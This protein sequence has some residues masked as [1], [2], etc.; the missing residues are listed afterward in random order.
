MA[1]NAAQ[2]KQG[3]KPEAP[4]MRT[5]EAGRVKFRI[6]ERNKEVVVN[7]GFKTNVSPNEFMLMQHIHGEENVEYVGKHMRE[8]DPKKGRSGDNIERPM[9]ER[10]AEVQRGFDEKGLM[11]WEP[12]TM[13]DERQY[14]E[15][16][17]GE[18]QVK[19]MFG[20]RPRF[21]WTFADA[22]INTVRKNNVVGIE[23]ANYDADQ[24]EKIRRMAGMA[25]GDF[26]GDG[27]EDGSG[28]EESEFEQDENKGGGAS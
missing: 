16:M 4:A 10:P 7:E 1:K 23:E 6:M 3:K 17:Y 24:Q 28:D 9:I 21:F 12:R 27:N 15:S 22:G 19:A 14:L 25:E 18:K 2:N 26:D 5:I 8:E 13:A 11:K 20:Q